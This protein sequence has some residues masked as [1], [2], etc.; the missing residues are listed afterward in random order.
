MVRSRLL[1]SVLAASGLLA[2]LGVGAGP[3]AVA[4]G[5]RS[6]A[7]GRSVAATGLVAGDW[8]GYRNRQGKG[9]F[10]QAESV[11]T[12]STVGSLHVVDT[13]SVGPFLLR[14]FQAGGTGN[15]LFYTRVDDGSEGMAAYDQA[16]DALRW[17][18][19]P[20]GNQLVVGDDAVYSISEEEQLGPIGHI[21]AH[22]PM[23]G[24]VL[25]QITLTTI[26]STSPPVLTGSTLVVSYSGVRHHVIT[27]FVRALNAKTGQQ[28]WRRSF[29]TNGAVSG[30]SV[31]AGNV[32]VSVNGVVTA[33]SLKNGKT[34]W[35]KPG[36]TS[37]ITPPLLSDGTVFAMVQSGRV[38]AWNATTG[39]QRWA[40]PVLDSTETQAMALA[41]GLLYVPT[42]PQSA[43]A[44]DLI[45]LDATNGAIRWTQS[46]GVRTSSPV[47]A[48]NVLYVYFSGAQSGLEAVAPTTGQALLAYTIPQQVEV[49]SEPMVSH[50]RMYIADNE[51]REIDVL[52]P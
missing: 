38:L 1:L 26:D 8:A 2:G 10:N 28:L 49:G 22:D 35:S 34:V 39:V 20:G 45:A 32:F 18:S 33:L 16:T 27:H 3:S 48:G 46:F 14:Q 23:T 6:D 11:L 24:A 47:V 5:S 17:T 43:T 25:W 15:G 7:A 9:A 42:F 19:H 51:Q 31:D 37:A 44:P 52:A 36:Q 4:A 13:I 40:T 29:P 12:R 21:S 50:G 41:N 30:P